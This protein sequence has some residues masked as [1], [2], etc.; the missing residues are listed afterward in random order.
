MNKRKAKPTHPL[1]VCAIVRYGSQIPLSL[2]TTNKQ[3]DHA[4]VQIEL[5][6][7]LVQSLVLVFG[8]QEA[9]PEQAVRHTYPNLREPC[10]SARGLC[11]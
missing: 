3:L 5:D 2:S 10:L 1:G 8:P 6:H 9:L 4:L 11:A 7:V